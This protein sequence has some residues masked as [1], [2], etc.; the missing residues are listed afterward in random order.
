MGWLGW[1]AG[2]ARDFRVELLSDRGSCNTTARSQSQENRPKSR[3]PVLN[4]PDGALHQ[5]SNVVNVSDSPIG[6]V[7]SPRR[8]LNDM[9]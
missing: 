1:K 7:D 2:T 9:S 5:L 3:S 6:T 4:V 8:E